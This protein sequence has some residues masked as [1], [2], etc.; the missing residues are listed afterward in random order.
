MRKRFSIKQ[1]ELFP[2]DTITARKPRKPE[3]LQLETETRSTRVRPMLSRKDVLDRFEVVE[4]LV[5]K[6]RMQ[7]WR[8]RYRLSK[9]D[10][11]DHFD[12]IEEIE[13]LLEK[14]RSQLCWDLKLDIWE[15]LNYLL[16]RN[17][18]LIAR[19]GEAA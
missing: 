11:L 15:A 2:I 9:K 5:N 3:R 17:E 1:L 14:A 7:L 8:V 10:V 6:A 13:G 4:G 12:D 18:E 19:N 16:T